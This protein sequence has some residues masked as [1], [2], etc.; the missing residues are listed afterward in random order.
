M[1]PVPDFFQLETP[2]ARVMQ[3]EWMIRHLALDVTFF[4]HLFGLEIPQYTPANIPWQPHSLHDDNL[5]K[6]D[7]LWDMVLHL[8]SF[9][10]FNTQ[11]AA[12]LLKYEWEDTANSAPVWVPWAGESIRSYIEREGV[13]A[14]R[15]VNT[16]LTSFRF[17]N[18]YTNRPQSFAQHS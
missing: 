7:Q 4:Y 6:L 13:A 9:T 10:R 18:R 3:L 2:E 12:S 1:K 15:I 14:L 5:Q 11:A 16:W 17:A 8:L